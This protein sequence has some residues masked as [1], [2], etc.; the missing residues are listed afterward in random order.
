[1]DGNVNKHVLLLSIV[2]C[3]P[4]KSYLLIYTLL[5]DSL[6]ILVDVTDSI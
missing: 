2:L 3:C 6:R 4:L 1:M 5:S